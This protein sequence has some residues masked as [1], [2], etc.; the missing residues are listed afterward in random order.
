[1]SISARVLA[2]FSCN[3]CTPASP[4][5]TPA[6]ILPKSQMGWIRRTSVRVNTLVQEMLRRLTSDD[7]VEMHCW[8][9]GCCTPFTSGGP[10]HVTL[11]D[12]AS[13]DSRS[14]CGSQLRLA[15]EICASTALVAAWLAARLG[16]LV[17]AAWINSGRV[18]FLA[19]ARV[20]AATASK[21]VATQI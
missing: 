1:M 19:S 11:G 13:S 21:K 20:P 12:G 4:A 6:E 18:N 15:S 8:V 17:W 7:V 9:S 16:L 5:A 10:R 14:P 2:C 3:A